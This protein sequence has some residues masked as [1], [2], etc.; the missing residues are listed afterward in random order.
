MGTGRFAALRFSCAGGTDP[1]RYRQELPPRRVRQAERFIQAFRAHRPEETAKAEAV[2]ALFRQYDVQKPSGQRE[3]LRRWAALEG[4]DRFV[5]VSA[6]QRTP[7]GNY[8]LPFPADR[9]RPAKSTT[10]A[11]K[12]E[13][14]TPLAWDQTC[15]RFQPLKPRTR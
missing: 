7:Q 5:G 10:K 3:I 8:I 1:E 12:L 9:P 13:S 11:Y 6:Y 15:N 2:L 14:V 4:V